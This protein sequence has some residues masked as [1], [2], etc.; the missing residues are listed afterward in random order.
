MDSLVLSIII[1]IICLIAGV[2]AG[3]FIFAVNT[4]KQ[5]EEAEIQSKRILADAQQTAETLKKE[6]NLKQKKGSFN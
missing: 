1:G 6:K 5:L 3:K 4:K 2:V